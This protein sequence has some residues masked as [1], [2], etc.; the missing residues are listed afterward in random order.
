MSKSRGD[1]G[2][3][4]SGSQ[5]TQHVTQ[6]AIIP[7]KFLESDWNE[8]VEI[9]SGED[10][11]CDIVAEISQLACDEVFKN[12]IQK[13]VQPYAVRGA[14]EI[15]LEILEWN[16]LEN[17]EGELDID[18]PSWCED[19]EPFS[20]ITDSWAQGAIPV[21]KNNTA[22]ESF[23]PGEENIN[24]IP[25]SNENV[26]LENEGDQRHDGEEE[27][28]GDRSDEPEEDN[29]CYS[30]QNENGEEEIE[31]CILNNDE[32]QPE[33]SPSL[34]L[35]PQ[36]PGK[37]KSYSGRQ[38]RNKKLF[39]PYGGSLP[40]FHSISSTPVTDDRPKPGS[41]NP[42]EKVPVLVLSELFQ[43]SQHGRPPG[44][45]E[46]VFDEKGNVTRVQKLNIESLPNH[47]VRT[48][49]KITDAEE[50][51]NRKGSIT[52]KQ[53]RSVLKSKE[54]SDKHSKPVANSAALLRRLYSNDS[55]VLAGLRT[56]LP[57]PMVDAI[58]VAEGV[59]IREG[60]L[61]KQG[62]RKKTYKNTN[63]DLYLQPLSSASTR[64]LNVNDIVVEST[65]AITSF[66]NSQP[67]PA[68][69]SS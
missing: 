31:E 51:I 52:S 25:E 36:P 42:I 34:V 49:Y 13:R 2:K 7:G 23:E 46:A 59:I 69:S 9:E 4:S 56:P 66:N 48:K 16:F 32:V 12:A 14:R 11:I 43:K 17:D 47:R 65:P 24:E 33:V 50:D 62:P 18:T 28:S 68:I 10:F 29:G 64:I 37:S 3:T 35:K 39:R 63:E 15:L 1:R 40:A 5:N 8:L 38:V 30:K 45:R 22:T 27:K 58:D 19:D 54:N 21:I 26:Q 44:V 67:L 57:P 6:N 55:D 20:C 61:S 60:G 41:V 53:R